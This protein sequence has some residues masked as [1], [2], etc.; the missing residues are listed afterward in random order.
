MAE[1]KVNKRN[2]SEEIAALFEE[3]KADEANALIKEFLEKE[4]ENIDAHA[5]AGAY[6]GLTDE[7]GLKHLTYVFERDITYTHPSGDILK[8]GNLRHL[9][10]IGL[11]LSKHDIFRKDKDK[12]KSDK[13]PREASRKHAFWAERFLSAG[14]GIPNIHDYGESLFELER[15]DEVI[16]LAYYVVGQKT[17][18]ELGFPGLDYS[19]EHLGEDVWEMVEKAMTS[20]FLTER[21]V[22]GCRWIH[23]RILAYDKKSTDYIDLNY[24][25]FL[26]GQTLAWMGWPEETARAWIIAVHKGYADYQYNMLFEDLCEMVVD[27]GVK[28][29]K[30]YYSRLLSMESLLAPEK[31]HEYEEI[32]KQALNAMMSGDCEMP[33]ESF[34]EKKLGVALP[35]KTRKKIYKS[36][37]LIVPATKSTDPVIKEVIATIDKHAAEMFTKGSDDSLG[38]KP[39]LREKVAVGGWAGTGYGATL[40]QFGVDLTRQAA[41]GDMPPVIGRDR[42]IERMMRILSRAEKNNPIL[43]GEAGVG[44]TAVV[45]GLAQRIVRGEVPGELKTKRIIELNVGVL[46]AG[47]TYRGDFEDRIT[48]IVSETREDPDIILFIDE[49]HTLMGAGA[50]TKRGLDGSNILK[51]ALAAGELR[52]IGATTAGEYSRSIEKDAAMERRFSPVW[53]SEIDAETTRAVVN[54][55]KP[56]WEKHHGVTIDADACD[57][58]IQLTDQYVRHRHFPDKAIDALDEACALARIQVPSADAPCVVTRDNIKRVIDEWSGAEA[59][60]ESDPR[61]SLLAQIRGRLEERIFGSRDIVEH[62]SRVAAEEKLGLRFSR[63][64]RV[65]CFAGCSQGG[66]TQ[67]ARALAHALWP[68][69]K[70][71]FLFINMAHLRAEHELN[72]LIGAPRGYV[73]SDTGGILPIH[74]KQFPHSVVFLYQFP[75]AHPRIMRFFGNLFAQGHFPD[76]DGQ[77][78]YAGSTLFVLSTSIDE[79]ISSIGFTAGKNEKKSENKPEDIV[80][81]LKRKQVPQTVINSISDFFRFESPNKEQVRQIIERHLKSAFDQPGIRELSA[82]IKP[83]STDELVKKF[84]S[85]PSA[86]RDLR[87]LLNREAYDIKQNS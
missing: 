53:L 84:M 45:Q 86:T 65:V 8:E 48:S 36:D 11:S 75:E 57:A 18:G 66:K 20:F 14:K 31:K 67:T 10:L 55:R 60:K 83:A 23:E 34:V 47:T 81:V 13:N 69:E 35:A 28:E 46:V 22:D 12:E 26:L 63:L 15:Y 33:T 70:E 30:D 59:K 62:L 73:G 16:N 79:T 6:A 76:P 27:K 43:L 56:L 38:L 44:K 58:A 82:G 4:P 2:Y 72:R 77:N 80:Q 54:A 71:R 29:K 3:K 5:W 9:F 40:E 50:T 19:K 64:P 52:L 39:G 51:P 87:A 41:K 74:L 85:T 1:N 24:L 17:A 61:N 49:L 7:D 37:R 42:E 32:K 25:F 78:V 21:Y 68:E